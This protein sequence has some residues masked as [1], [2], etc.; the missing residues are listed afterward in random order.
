MI[1]EPVAASIAALV[2]MAVDVVV[3]FIVVVVVVVAVAILAMMIGSVRSHL[4]CGSTAWS[5]T[6]KKNQLALDKAQNQSLRLI[7]GVMRST[8]ITEMER[9]TEVQ[10]LGQRTDSKILMQTDMF[11]CMPNHPLKTRL[12]GLAKNRLKS[13][14]VHGSKKLS[15]QFHDRLP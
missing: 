7:T 1:E 11:R 14:F 9:I 6:T 15:R 13:S 5:A 2:V 3:V 4:E 12:E 8:P 10:P